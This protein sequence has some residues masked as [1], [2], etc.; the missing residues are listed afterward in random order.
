MDAV[1]RPLAGIRAAE[2]ASPTLT[3]NLVLIHLGQPDQPTTTLS[4]TV[5]VDASGTAEV[6]FTG[7]PALPCIGDLRLS[8]GKVGS[9]S[10]F[11]GLAELRA[12]EPTTLVIVPK[13]TA[14]DEDVAVRLV[15]RVLAEK[16]VFA[17]LP[18]DFT[19]WIRLLLTR[20]DLKNPGIL[21]LAFSA[22]QDSFDT[23][24]PLPTATGSIAVVVPQ[25]TGLATASLK[26][27][28]AFGESLVSETGSATVRRSA[29]PASTPFSVDVCAN[30]SENA[31]LLRIHHPESGG[32]HQAIS[33]E[34]TAE[35]FILID[36][37]LPTLTSAQIAQVRTLLPQ[38]AKYPQLLTALGDAI[39]E[40]PADPLNPE[41]HEVPHDLAAEISAEIINQVRPLGSIRNSSTPACP[42]TLNSKSR[43][44]IVIEN[45]A[46]CFYN[47]KMENLS[48]RTTNNVLVRRAGYGEDTCGFIL[49]PLT[50]VWGWI[51]GSA[52]GDK[53]FENRSGYQRFTFTK[54]VGI[55]VADG[56]LGVAVAA[57]GIAKPRF[58]NDTV[59]LVE[60][61]QNI[62]SNYV[63]GS[64]VEPRKLFGRLFALGVEGAASSYN[65]IRAL[66]HAIYRNFEKS[67]LKATIMIWLRKLATP[68]AV[69]ELAYRTVDLVKIAE[70]LMYSPNKIIFPDSARWKDVFPV[71]RFE[72]VV[73]PPAV[74]EPGE[75]FIPVETPGTVFFSPVIA[76][77]TMPDSSLQEV[78]IAPATSV[79]TILYQF[80]YSDEVYFY[81]EPYRFTAPDAREVS[82][83]NCDCRLTI[84]RD[85][86]IAASAPYQIAVV[87]RPINAT[88]AGALGGV[89]VS[90]DPIPGAT[91]YNVYWNES[92][93]VIA[94]GPN[95]KTVS[96]ATSS[97]IIPGMSTTEDTYFVVTTLGPDLT[98]PQGTIQAESKPSQEVFGMPGSG[99][100]NLVAVPGKEQVTLSWSPLTGATGY[101]V[102][103]GTEANMGM[104]NP[105]VVSVTG[106]S[107]TVTNLTNYTT[108]YFI[109][110]GFQGNLESR[111]SAEVSGRPGKF[112]KDPKTGVITD[113]DTTWQWYEGYFG[114]M[115]MTWDQSVTWA[116]NLNVDGGGWRMATMA[117][118]GTLG[119][120]LESGVFNTYAYRVLS[121]ELVPFDASQVQVYRLDNGT[122]SS[123]DRN[124]TQGSYSPIVIRKK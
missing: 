98:T 45:S 18:Q 104:L 33:L 21:D 57:L 91:G 15:L 117:E 120:P 110:S 66:N 41:K 49:S 58:N 97:A 83:T 115:G 40:D 94:T 46:N 54:D 43:D 56:L 1:H 68:V 65:L 17:R 35:A 102:W 4:K 107:H 116:G 100:E 9:F 113:Q 16:A 50:T 122:T 124:S 70:A 112:T 44:I 78:V 27:L 59:E 95:R 28:N 14:M 25:G 19:A 6:T 118:L 60:A 87:P 30:S 51:A 75:S 119:T 3:A 10:D 71:G 92:P 69:A 101:H 81:V 89:Q 53:E 72:N 88:A 103:W 8:G 12:T 85:K 114:T 86:T 62:F 96:A 77:M 121:S 63:A 37:L 76:R 74:L 23:G 61:C 64:S 48:L 38:H 105:N 32:G 67:Y 80:P 99:P 7:V 22:L 2:A 90:W 106:T 82:L 93:G 26:V 47:A 111:A 108:Y 34:S 20:F 39:R 11:H 84:L 29:D 55:S 5:P 31:V 123:W 73:L 13:D 79:T 109:V 24:F 42:I 36:P 52:L